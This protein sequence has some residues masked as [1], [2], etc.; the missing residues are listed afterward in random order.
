MNR[1][2]RPQ[3]ASESARICRWRALRGPGFSVSRSSM[4]PATTA[5]GVPNSCA[6]AAH[7]TACRRTS[8]CRRALVLNSS[9]RVAPERTGATLESPSGPEEALTNAWSVRLASPRP[10]L[11]AEAGWSFGISTSPRTRDP[12]RSR[13]FER[14]VFGLPD[15]PLESVLQA[16]LARAPPVPSHRRASPT[17]TQRLPLPRGEDP[18][19]FP[20][21]PG[22]TMLP[23]L[24]RHVKRNAQRLN[25]VEE[26]SCTSKS[27][28]C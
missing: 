2:R 6:A 9:S 23:C 28:R 15:A 1:C 19:A 24:F 11:S 8:S 22:R 25:I 13:A 7:A 16:F 27:K 26:G 3:L 12:P 4:Y 18:P 17:T 10:S 5:R 21:L 14:R 20:S